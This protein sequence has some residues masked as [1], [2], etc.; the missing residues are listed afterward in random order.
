MRLCTGITDNTDQ[1]EFLGL[2]LKEQQRSQYGTTVHRK[3]GES[4]EWFCPR[5]QREVRDLCRTQCCDFITTM[6]KD[7]P[8]EMHSAHTRCW[9]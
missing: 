7:I 3:D 1:S 8:R 2:F 9:E 6:V 5:P 4:E